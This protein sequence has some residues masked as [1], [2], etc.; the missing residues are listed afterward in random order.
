MKSTERMCTMWARKRE[1]KRKATILNK[2]RANVIK[3]ILCVEL[4]LIIF[5]NDMR[6][7]RL[8]FFLLPYGPFVPCCLLFAFDRVS[9]AF[10]CSFVLAELA[11][12][13][14]PHVS[15]LSVRL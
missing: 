13:F 7:S 4:W 6:F 3:T 10:L 14:G 2:L 12:A 11:V 8:F 15:F 9:T 1:N 5:C